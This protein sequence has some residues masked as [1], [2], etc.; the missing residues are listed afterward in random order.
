L[1]E[2]AIYTRKTNSSQLVVGVYVDDLV[3]TEE[4]SEDI[5]CFKQEMDTAFR[6]S[7]LGFFGITLG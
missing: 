2:L 5:S 4:D 3:I 7:D 6:M 1:L